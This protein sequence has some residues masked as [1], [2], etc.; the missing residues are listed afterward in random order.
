MTAMI[1]MY[2]RI[3]ADL[4]LLII[5]FLDQINEVVK[6]IA[7]LGGLLLLYFTIKK[8]R[9][10]I[11]LNNIKKKQEEEKLERHGR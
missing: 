9:L 6:L 8:I 11:A 4:A 10:D 1:R 7:G 2:V 3:L 5:P